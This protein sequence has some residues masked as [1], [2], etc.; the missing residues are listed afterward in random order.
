MP[1]K[2]KTKLTTEP[3][4]VG[5]GAA[6]ATMPPPPEGAAERVEADDAPDL[7]TFS[8]PGSDEGEKQEAP[9]GPLSY[10][11]GEDGTV[12]DVER[13]TQP[14]LPLP[15]TNGNGHPKR[16]QLT[17]IAGGSF[18]P[19][20]CKLCEAKCPPHPARIVLE[21][22]LGNVELTLC[23]K[24]D[25]AMTVL[26]GLIGPGDTTLRILGPGGQLGMHTA[27]EGAL[28]DEDGGADVDEDHDGPPAAEVAERIRAIAAQ[29]PD[30]PY[31]QGAAAFCEGLPMDANPY[32]GPADQLEQRGQ[33]DDGWRRAQTDQRTADSAE[34][35]EEEPAAEGEYVTDDGVQNREPAGV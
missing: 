18:N 13:L 14:E 23:A 32:I 16:V 22:P 28:G 17:L 25:T 10:T 5:P 4:A 2:P 21:R 31:D 7:E 15:T 35:R 20:K 27:L 29:L 1:R 26:I 9:T 19:L 34:A 12:G 24:C 33:W 11:V 8:F 6:T 30:Q 3:S